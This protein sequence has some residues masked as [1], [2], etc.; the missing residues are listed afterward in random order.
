AR[1]GRVRAGHVHPSAIHEKAAAPQLPVRQGGRTGRVLAEPV[2][3]ADRGRISVLRRSKVTRRPWL[4][5]GAV[6]PNVPYP[7]VD[8]LCRSSFGGVTSVPS[9]RLYGTEFAASGMATSSSLR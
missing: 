6:R 9:A 2:A 8:N 7:E 3:A 5:S 1:G 4:L